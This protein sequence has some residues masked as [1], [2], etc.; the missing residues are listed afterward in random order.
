MVNEPAGA[1]LGSYHGGGCGGQVAV[2]LLYPSSPPESGCRSPQ[3]VQ[4]RAIAASGVF[5]PEEKARIV[6]GRTRARTW[7]PL[8][9]SQL[10][11]Q[12]SYASISVKEGGAVSMQYRPKQHL[13]L[14]CGRVTS[15]LTFQFLADLIDHRLHAE[16][17]VYEAAATPSGQSSEP[18]AGEPLQRRIS[19]RGSAVIGNQFA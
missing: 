15:R 2:K 9:K 5:K 1:A 19:K 13:P 18:V 3:Q 16:S 10:L 17:F 6:G 12:L 4:L 8:I 11:C 14:S 7:D